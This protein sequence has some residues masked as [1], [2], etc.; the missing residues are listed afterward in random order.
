[1]FFKLYM[2]LPTSYQAKREWWRM[3]SGFSLDVI[4]AGTDKVCA[5]KPLR[6]FAFLFFFSKSCLFL[7]R[8]APD[9]SILSMTFGRSNQRLHCIGII[10]IHT[11]QS[12]SVDPQRRTGKPASQWDVNAEH[13][14]TAP[15]VRL[16]PPLHRPVPTMNAQSEQSP[17]I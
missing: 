14:A 9:Q 8:I 12:Q 5:L 11:P 7:Q 15:P 16:P 2:S 17:R 4:R 6:G 13:R 1:M 3:T 10:M